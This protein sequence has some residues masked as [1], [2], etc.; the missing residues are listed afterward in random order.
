MRIKVLWA[1]PI[2]YDHVS[3]AWSKKSERFWYATTQCMNFINEKYGTLDTIC[4]ENETNGKS[5]G[6]RSFGEE[7]Y[8]SSVGKYY[9]M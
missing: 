5:Y 7:S 3:I 4:M 8:I 2:G 9:R 1:T 6:N